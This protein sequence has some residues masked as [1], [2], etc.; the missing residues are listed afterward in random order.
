MVIEGNGLAAEAPQMLAIPFDELQHHPRR[1]GQHHRTGQAGI[2]QQ[3]PTLG[4]APDQVGS[5]AQQ[6]NPGVDGPGEGQQRPRIGCE[7]AGHLGSSR[8]EP[9]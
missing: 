6:Q 3:P 7:E 2:E 5:V 1:G 9:L 4:P 8:V